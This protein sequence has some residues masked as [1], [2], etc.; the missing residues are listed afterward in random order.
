MTG[1]SALKKGWLSREIKAASEEIA[2]W[3]ANLKRESYA[4]TLQS[5][6]SRDVGDQIGKRA[7]SGA[8]K[9]SR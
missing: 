6:R 8:K 4:S 2:A 3:P 5:F 1:R 7:S 9:A